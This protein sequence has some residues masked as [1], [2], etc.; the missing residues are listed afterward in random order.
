MDSANYFQ[1]T[2]T[3]SIDDHHHSPM[4]Q[5]SIDNMDTVVKSHEQDLARHLED[6]ARSNIGFH[7][8][9]TKQQLPRPGINT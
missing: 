7:W 9:G 5:R 2:E 3:P 6:S 1:Q 8:I 4:A